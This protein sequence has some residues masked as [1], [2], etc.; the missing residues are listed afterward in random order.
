M[1]NMANDMDKTMQNE[2]D[3]GVV[4][5]YISSSKLYTALQSTN[6]NYLP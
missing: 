2:M 5:S 3:T 4:C 1:V 6:P